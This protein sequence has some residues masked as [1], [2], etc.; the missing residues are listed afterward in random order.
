MSKE[1]LHQ[2]EL[3]LQRLDAAVVVRDPG[4]ARAAEAYEGLRK[5][6]IR[7]S[8]NHRAH[9]AHLLSLSDSLERGAGIELVRDRVNDFLAEL[10]VKYV[11]D[12]SIPELFEV[13]ETVLGEQ[14]GFEILEVAVAEQMDDGN[15]NPIRKG[16]VRVIKGPE[17]TIT[18]QSEA[19][20]P[21]REPT[22]DPQRDSRILA[23][24][25]AA[26]I[27]LV[28]GLILGK[29]IFASDS[30]GSSPT[31]STSIP[32]SQTVVT[33]STIQPSSSTAPAITTTTGA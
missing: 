30:S 31:R 3:L 21:L 10:G 22:T 7:S 32:T 25:V 16:K 29:F 26:G 14:D 5:Q 27:A 33:S 15:I 19:P 20:T 28:F 17:P 18:A 13:A 9:I 2:I 1:Q 6:I 4:N 24:S 8:T 23:I 12:Y 11:A